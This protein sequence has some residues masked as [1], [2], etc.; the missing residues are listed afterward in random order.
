MFGA[1]VEFCCGVVGKVVIGANGVGLAGA[2]EVGVDPTTVHCAY[3]VN[4][5]VLPCVH[6][7]VIAVPPLD[8][9]NQ[10]ANVWPSR[11]GVPGDEI[12]PPV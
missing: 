12:E 2:T 6:G 1:S 8:V 3:S 5:A 9:S 4:D 11:V 7:K 10:P